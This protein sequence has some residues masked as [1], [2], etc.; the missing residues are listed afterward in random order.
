[1]RKLTPM[2]SWR[3]LLR[4][5]FLVFLVSDQLPHS[6]AVAASISSSSNAVIRSLALPTVGDA[7][8]RIIAPAILELN[9]ITTKP[10]D[11]A[12]VQE[13]DFVGENF[14]LHAP[15][16]N[17]FTVLVG[18]KRVVVT[19]VG[20]KRRVVF[21][22]LKKRDLRIG[23]QLYLELKSPIAPGQEVEVQSRSGTLWK[24]GAASFRARMDVARWSPAIHVNQVGY[25]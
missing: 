3:V 7:E 20:F 2:L 23:N 14:A 16:P 11:P 12:R 8:L 15:A 18:G 5:V 17:D 25:V 24:P 19:Q 9:L 1:M 10:P 21:A 22:P 13:W 6:R 4:I